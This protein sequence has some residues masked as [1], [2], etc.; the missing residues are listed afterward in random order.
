VGIGL[1]LALLSQGWAEVPWYVGKKIDAVMIRN[2][3]G[4]VPEGELGNLLNSQ[5]DEYL[6]V[7]SVR[8]DIIMLYT[9]GDFESVE[10]D[11]LT[12]PFNEEEVTVHIEYRV[13]EA[14]KLS[15]IN[16]EGSDRG[17]DDLILDEMN[18]SLGQPFYPEVQIWRLERDVSRRLVEEG[19]PKVSVSMK[20]NQNEDLQSTLDVIVQPNDIRQFKDIE[21]VNLPKDLRL[22]AWFVMRR[23]GMKKGK[24]IRLSAL[25]RTREQLKDLLVRNGWIQAKVDLALQTSPSG[26]DYLRVLLKPGPQLIIERE[27]RNLPRKSE[28]Q[29]ILGIYAGDRIGQPD[30]PRFKEAL[31]DWYLKKGFIDAVADVSISE[32]NGDIILTVD[33]D[34][35]LHHRIESIH[36]SDGELY[37]TEELLSTLLEENYALQENHLVV[38]EIEEGIERIEEAYRGKGYFETQIEYQIEELGK[39]QQQY[40]YALKVDIIEGRS[41]K[42]GRLEFIG[43]KEELN[44][45]VTLPED[46]Y[47]PIRIEQ[48]K[49]ELINIYQEQG[50]LYVDVSVDVVVNPGDAVADVEIEIQHLD[51]PVLLRNIAI[52]GNQRT[53][54]ALMKDS[55]D[56]EVGQPIRPSDIKSARQD[57]YELDLF[58]SVNIRLY[59]DDEGSQDLLIDVQER[60]NIELSIGGAA[61]T[62]QGVLATSS[63]KYRNLFGIGHQMSFIGQFGYSWDEEKWWTFDYEEPVWKLATTYTANRFPIP[64]SA[65]FVETLFQEVVQEPSYRMLRSGGGVGLKISP[66]PSVNA[67]LE[68]RIHQMR[69]DDY[70]SGLFIEGEPWV[71]LINSD[72]PVRWSSGVR[73]TLIVDMRDNPFNPTSG[74]IFSGELQIG[75]GFINQLPTVRLGT[76]FSA[77]FT[78]DPLRY[79]VDISTGL[80]R[81]SDDSPVAL[82]DRFFI[83]GPNTMRGFERNSVGPA[84]ERPWTD[85]NYPNQIEGTIDDAYLSGSPTHWVNTGGDAFWLLNFEMHYP[86]TTSSS[87]DPGTSII[88]FM[89]IGKLYYISEDP[90]TD[91]EQQNLDPLLRYSTGVGL[92]ITTVLGP[93]AIDL[94]LNPR[95]LD[96]R[97][98]PIS[99]IHL[100]L[101][102]F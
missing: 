88:T 75:D 21:L 55:L 77:I 9:I 61:A 33:A 54:I 95:R 76:D 47:E 12:N 92:R 57:L 79:K 46:N 83:G 19:W 100:S 102:A 45:L 56:L 99:Q 42:M 82:E 16:I 8:E 5:V 64:S 87:G 15:A 13:K 63:V 58:E 89:D 73:G 25:K 1:I 40:N 7:K 97:L 22:E 49:N 62:D 11:V 85:F 96:D 98:E 41:T 6:D 60:S 43:G 2:L 17:M 94:G 30:E 69:I 14:Y 37:K 70:E 72:N 44:S 68:Y 34:R 90:R 67:L 81:T 36:I 35:G 31:E 52:R 24:R 20:Y 39:Y 29:N 66:D 91:S 26:D 18:L 38:S 4:E 27:S 101:G 78:T 93:L 10:V 74:S 65:L 28:F 51:D 50:Y 48:L 53:K 86:L 3:D 23:L 32:L 84:N 59:G 80:A 71:A